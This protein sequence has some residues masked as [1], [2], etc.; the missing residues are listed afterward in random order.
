MVQIRESVGGEE[1]REME[2][3]RERLVARAE[4][5]EKLFQ[6]VPLTKVE[7]QKLK[8][9]TNKNKST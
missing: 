1:S 7:R 5:E 3:E 9:L 8:A 2:R 4:E 6:R